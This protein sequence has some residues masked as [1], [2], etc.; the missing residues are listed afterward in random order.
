MKSMGGTLSDLIGSG[1]AKTATALIAAAKDETARAVEKSVQA[2]R[3]VWEGKSEPERKKLA[4]QAAVR[5]TKHAGHRVKCPACGSD[6]LV[7]GGPVAPP[8]VKLK[9]ELIV[10]K[11]EFLPSKFECTACGLKISGLPQLH[12]CGL[13]SPYTSTKSYDPADYYAVEVYGEYEP[14]NND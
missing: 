13:A 4:A 10:E 12:V 6:A 8:V 11:Q 9:D 5:A 14:D 1:E 3:T 7:N 2:H